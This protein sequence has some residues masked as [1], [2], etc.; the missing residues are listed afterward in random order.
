MTKSGIILFAEKFGNTYSVFYKPILTAET[1]MPKTSTSKTEPAARKSQV[2]KTQA[3]N[4]WIQKRQAKKSPKVVVLESDFAGIKKGAKLH[5][6]TPELIDAYIRKIPEGEVRTI[7]RLRNEL[8][9]KNG[10]DATC[11]VSSAIF[12]RIVAE[13]A[14][15]E[16]QA[17]APLTKVT[18]FWRVIEPNTAIAKRLSV[19]SD[20]IAHQ[21]EMET[22]AS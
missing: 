11:P 9:R 7:T 13:A 6:S 2:S 10:A 19:G 17:G 4:P 8:A 15:G 18:P 14:W 5:V 20:W 21:R 12:L 3:I 1:N 16:I 22:S